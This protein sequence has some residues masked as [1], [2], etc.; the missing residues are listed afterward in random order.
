[1]G[2]STNKRTF[3]RICEPACP[4]QA[5]VNDFGQVEKLRPDPGHPTGGIPCNKGLNFL[6]VHQD[7]DRL[8]WP[9]KRGNEKSANNSAEFSRINWDDALSEIAQQVLELQA[10]Y[11]KDSVAFYNGNPGSFDSRGSRISSKFLGLLQ[12]NKLFTAGTQD[13][14]NKT[15]VGK[16]MYGGFVYFV[17]DLKHTDYLLCLGANPKVSHWTMVG[18]PNDGGQILKDIATRGGKV[19]F[20]NPRK[21]E[22]SLQTTG[23][24]LQIKP[25]TDVY[26]LAALSNEVRKLG[27][28]NEEHLNK[29]GSNVETYLAFIQKWDADKV[30]SITGIAATD[31]K[32]VAMDMVAAKSAACYLSTGVNQGRQGTLSFWLSEMLNFASGNL[33]RKGG[34]YKPP[35]LIKL[36]QMPVSHYDWDSPDGKQPI[37]IGALPCTL[38]PEMIESGEIKALICFWGNPL[39]STS[40]G[41]QMRDAFSKLELL[42]TADILPTATTEL[43]DYVLPATDWLERA[44]ITGVPLNTGAQLIPNVQY[45]DAIVEPIQE[46]RHDWWILS[47]LLQLMN[48]PSLLDEPDHDDGFKPINKLLGF[49]GT[50]IEEVRQQPYQTLMLE[51]P[52]KESL[53]ET[54]ILFEDGKIDCFP[55]IFERTGLFQR[56]KQIWDELGNEQEDILKLISMRTPQMHNSWMSNAPSMRTGSLAENRLR[57]N[58]FDADKRGLFEGDN[59]EV[60]NDNGK[61]TCTLEIRDDIRPGAVAMTHGYGNHFSQSLSVASAKPGANYNSLTPVGSNSYEPCSFMSWMCGVA[62]EVERVA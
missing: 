38:L 12:S 52:P 42:V 25:D 48:L 40:G 59:I 16:A 21:I 39:L 14:S 11:G 47:R 19:K 46:R 24:T 7:P 3:C 34:T 33:G 37:V 43:A 61:L 26:F 15:A 44:D 20:V 35:G 60:S 4:L 17:P 41:Q 56:F 29:H 31:I 62:V 2:L 5:E 22:S 51:Q 30:A 32:G 36:R 18:V 9:L 45:T 53:Y 10:K 13:C 27:G 50:S 54:S 49:M 55:D 8:N 58:S 1:M 6:E 28:F 23:D 57:M